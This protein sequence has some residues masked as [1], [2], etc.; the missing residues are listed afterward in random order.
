MIKEIK[1]GVLSK[2][3]KRYKTISADLRKNFNGKKWNES[4]QLEYAAEH[5]LE[6]L[7]NNHLNINR[8]NVKILARYVDTFGGPRAKELLAKLQPYADF[9]LKQYAEMSKLSLRQKLLR[10]LTGNTEKYLS[11]KQMKKRILKLEKLDKS[12]NW[13]FGIMSKKEKLYKEAENYINTVLEGKISVKP[14]DR[15]TFI[16]YVKFFSYPIYQDSPAQQVLA[17]IQK[18]I[19]EQPVAQ[20]TPK[21][22][23]SWGKFLRNRISNKVK[24]AVVTTLAVAG[25][26][27]GLKSCEKDKQD[28]I[29]QKPKSEI[30]AAP[31]KPVVRDTVSAPK[32][33]IEFVAAQT[34]SEQKIWNNYYDN[35][36]EIFMSA[37]Q[38]NKLYAKIESQIANGIFELPNGVSKEKFAYCVAVYK[39]Y[40]LKTSLENA[41]NSTTKLSK[42][43]AQQMEKDISAAGKKGEGA[44][45]IAERVN[46]GKLKKYS[47]FDH[48]SSRLQ[49]QHAKTLADIMKLKANGGR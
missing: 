43:A 15:R 13:N 42:E 19:A 7:E 48:S 41:L 5:F 17:K 9:D 44:K 33:Q 37:A 25:S 4:C 1:T 30:M 8:N 34:S 18:Q 12:T 16:K 45:K 10:A 14:E 27:M 22:K 47:K 35:T 2:Q 3:M 46:H 40:G 39:E 23:S 24:I 32:A 6:D 29:P 21:E 36:V 26:L 28:A 11:A 20:S 31:A 49:K 38:K